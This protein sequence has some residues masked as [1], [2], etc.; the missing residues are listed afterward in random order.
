MNIYFSKATDLDMKNKLAQAL[1]E[2]YKDGYM[3]GEFYHLTSN[4]DGSFSITI[5]LGESESDRN[6]GVSMYKSS[7]KDSVTWTFKP[8]SLSISNVDVSWIV[9]FESDSHVSLDYAGKIIKEHLG[10][11]AI[12]YNYYYDSSNAVK[13]PNSLPSDY[14]VNA[15]QCIQNLENRLNMPVFVDMYNT[16][17]QTTYANIN[18]LMT[19]FWSLHFDLP[20]EDLC[21][22]NVNGFNIGSFIVNC[23]YGKFLHLW[24]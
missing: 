1:L 15:G 20:L 12:A 6:S 3:K 18:E 4:E 5:V 22:L 19:N 8:T 17:F 9:D 24:G 16:K 10:D 7:N 14:Y 21:Y 13:M 2:C 23:T 11:F